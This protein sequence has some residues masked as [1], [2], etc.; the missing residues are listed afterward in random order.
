MAFIAEA[1]LPP[2]IEF[3]LAQTMGLPDVL[4]GSKVPDATPGDDDDGRASQD[5]TA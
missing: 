4:P 2:E 3:V 5:R 1:A